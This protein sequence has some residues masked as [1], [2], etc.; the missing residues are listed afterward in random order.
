M[1]YLS[2]TFHEKDQLPIGFLTLK[3]NP[4]ASANKLHHQSKELEETWHVSKT[5]SKRFTLYS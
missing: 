4:E 1:A 2:L 3:I 5:Q